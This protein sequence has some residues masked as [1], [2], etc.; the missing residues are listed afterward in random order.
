MPQGLGPKR[1]E[2]EIP[3]RSEIGTPD[4]ESMAGEQSAGQTMDLEDIKRLPS[5]SLAYKTRKS[6]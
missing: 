3:D 1:P 6:G 4:K 2:T 5:Y